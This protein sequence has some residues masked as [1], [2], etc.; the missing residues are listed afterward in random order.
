[1]KPKPFTEGAIHSLFLKSSVPMVIGLLANLLVQSFDIWL[2]AK[3]PSDALVAMGYIFPVVMLFI[4]IAIAISAGVASVLARW[5]SQLSQKGL[6]SRLVIT[7]GVGLIASS[8]LVLFCLII[9]PLYPM[10]MGIEQHIA[11][12]VN[13]YLSVYFINGWL[14]FIGM[15][16]L[17]S[18]RALGLPNIQGWSML[19]AALVQAVLAPICIFVFEWG[20]QG[21]A[22]AGVIA[23]SLP[24]FI[25]YFYLHKAFRL[26]A[27][28]LIDF[29][30]EQ[31]LK[32][33][34]STLH[35]AIP[36]MLNNLFIPIAS[37]ITTHLVATLGEAQVAAFAIAAHIEPVFLLV[38]HALSAIL[39][40]YMGQNLMANRLSRV[41]QGLI[42]S[43]NFCFITGLLLALVLF[44]LAPFLASLFTST[45]EIQA[46]LT[47]YLRIVPVSY[48]FSGVVILVNASFN[49]IGQPMPAMVISALRAFLLY[50]PIA[51]FAS[52]HYAFVG[53]FVAYSVINVLCAFLAYYWFKQRIR[54]ISLK[55]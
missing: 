37:F 27:F 46:Y 55:R 11:P 18:L 49:G 7:Q 16:G 41:D 25:A 3:L 52:I 42:I 15:V 39:A 30:K 23:K 21:S 1:M 48:G 32:T 43:R 54:Q 44:S 2:I 51:L 53:V 22:W 26:F 13:H 19:L 47:L 45:P 34:K 35:I 38:F 29:T 40:P 14:T 50:F 24:V 12:L 4:Y 33:T 9:L 31:I 6:H 17:S 8:L 20:L 36:A 28:K 10:I 5:S